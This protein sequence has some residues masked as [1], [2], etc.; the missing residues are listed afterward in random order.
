[1]GPNQERWL[2]A[3]ES[4]DYEQCQEFLHLKGKGH[5]CLGVACELFMGPPTFNN[6]DSVVGRW[7]GTSGVAP[8]TV[9][10][11]LGLFDDEGSS[12]DGSSLTGLNDSGKTFGEIAAIIRSS[13]SD[14]FFEER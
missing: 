5:C 4:G 6:D 3:L 13:P 12:T 9:Q 10:V 1:M 7:D 8:W 2:N 11:A 14:W